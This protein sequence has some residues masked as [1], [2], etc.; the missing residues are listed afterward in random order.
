MRFKIFFAL[1]ILTFT[2]GAQ[3][4]LN[5]MP[6]EVLSTSMAANR[7]RITTD[8]YDMPVAIW[9]EGSKLIAGKASQL[10]FQRMDTLNLPG[11]MVSISYWHGP[12]I[13]GKGDTLYVV[14]KVAPEA[15]TSH[16]IYCVASFD[17]G[18]SWMVPRRV[19]YV[20]NHMGRLPTIA[21]GPG[22]HPVVA[23]MLSD[24][25]YAEP[26]WVI[27]TS[28]DYGQ[29]FSP[30]VQVSGDNSAN[31]EAC[32]CCPA[33]LAVAGMTVHLAYR[34]N[35]SNVRN[36]RVASGTW[37][38]STYTSM[39]VDPLT[40]T[41]NACP[42]TGPDLAVLGDSLFATFQNAAQ[43]ED[44]FQSR[45][46]QGDS[47]VQ[48]QQI[49]PS[50][51]VQNYPRLDAQL[52]QDS[53]FSRGTVWKEG[54]GTQAKIRSKI[55][56]GGLPFWVDLDTGTVNVPDVAI[57]G[58]G[59][60]FVW[61]EVLQKRIYL[62]RAYFTAIGLDEPKGVSDRRLLHV[63]DLYGRVLESRNLPTGIYV[64]WYTDGSYEKQFVVQE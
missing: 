7:P 54:A 18:S 53:T 14:Y 2:L 20:G 58:Q 31:A 3:Q 1:S 56:H 12:E 61:H 51:L 59:V 57:S 21:K 5:W 43:A 4:T 28:T 10:T 9:G 60:F 26:Q 50:S 34:D 6:R 62:K 63:V 16:H 24:L 47:S 8:G 15:D 33:S 41:V 48:F 46:Q 49:S 45:W 30:V 25:N 42:A 13:A 52:W 40:W 39:N 38:D 22:G 44:V 17:G 23:F 35:V 55:V 36:I 19:D 32:D 27:T 29:T 64:F 37:Q 11:Q